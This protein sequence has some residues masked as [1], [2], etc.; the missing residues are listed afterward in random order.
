M[1]NKLSAAP[2]KAHHTL[3]FPDRDAYPFSYSF[4]LSRTCSYCRIKSVCLRRSTI[5]PLPP[6]LRFSSLLFSSRPSRTS[7]PSLYCQS[8]VTFLSHAHLRHFQPLHLP[9]VTLIDT[10]NG[11][12]TS[13]CNRPDRS[14]HPFAAA[15]SLLRLLPSS[16]PHIDRLIA[17]ACLLPFRI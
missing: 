3:H 13:H 8:L 1:S 17:V 4:G 15:H 6:S 12:L 2:F 14:C 5:F 10:R 9:S 11:R 7:S 16:R